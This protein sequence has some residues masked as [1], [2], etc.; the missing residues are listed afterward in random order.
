M[1]GLLFAGV[2]F[3]ACLANDAFRSS[4]SSG[5]V[6]GEEFELNDSI[7]FS[8]SSNLLGVSGGE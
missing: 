8:L 7:L 6:V 5:G 2:K 1:R 3:D 4:A